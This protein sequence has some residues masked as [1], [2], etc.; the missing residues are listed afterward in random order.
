M[1]A[2]HRIFSR[3]HIQGYELV[4]VKW[5]PFSASDSLA[6]YAPKLSDTIKDEYPILLGLS[7]GGMLAVEIGKIRKT[8]KILLISSAKVASE[9]P[10]I[11]RSSFSKNL[12]K[13]LPAGLFQ[14]PNYI[15]FKLLGAEHKSDWRIL[16]VMLEDTPAGFV[17][18]A[19]TAILSWD[20]KVCLTNIVQ[21][22]GTADKTIPPANVHPDHW[23]KGGGHIMV[24]NCAAE[25]AR[26][27]E[28]DLP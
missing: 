5:V 26:V 23:V 9:L 6:S 8:E 21:V 20:N 25:V 16:K 12:V 15:T 28:N 19:L 7:L 17:K 27:I 18:W 11:A 22:H 1:G 14:Q 3:L 10:A 24:Y 4:P 2:D 13:I